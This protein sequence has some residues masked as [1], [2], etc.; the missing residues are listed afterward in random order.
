MSEQKNEIAVLE[1][2]GDYFRTFA[3]YFCRCTIGRGIRTAEIICG[4]WA[5]KT[6]SNSQTD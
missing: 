4:L 1:K 6:I 5:S 3:R 2:K